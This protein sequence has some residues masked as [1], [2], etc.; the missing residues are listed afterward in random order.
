MNRTLG[1]LL[2]TLTLG[3]LV[4]PLAAHVQPPTHVHRI[5]ALSALGTP[6]GRDPLVEAFLEGMRARSRR[7]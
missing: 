4:A 7:I 3:A 2:I 6:P 1:A 5:G